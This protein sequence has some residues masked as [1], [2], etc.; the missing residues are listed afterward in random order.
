MG[1]KQEVLTKI[2][3]HCQQRGDFV[4]D[5][6]LVKEIC[7]EV[8]FKNP[9]DVTKIDRSALYP[10][11]MKQGTGYF[12]I[13]LG[14]G[15]H[16]FVPNVSLAYHQLEVIDKAQSIAWKYRP[17]LLNEFDTSESNIIS[18]GLNQRILHD[19]LY[20]D[21]EADAKQYMPRRTKITEQYTIDAREINV[22]NLQMEIDA[23]LEL[24]QCSH[25]Y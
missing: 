1:K 22:I 24:G 8:D 19:F 2:F 3:R 11:V 18:V 6:D 23:V 4:F 25:D 14:E 5:N 7:Q 12:I 10:D 21:I 9:F 20:D 15:Q 13:H 16:Q 17:S